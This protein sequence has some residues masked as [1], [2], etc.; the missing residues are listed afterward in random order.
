MYAAIFLI[1]NRFEKSLRNAELPFT[2][3]TA[4]AKKQP[5]N[6]SSKKQ[7]YKIIVT[8]NIFQTV[9]DAK[10]STILKKAEP[11]SPTSLNLSLVGTIVGE[12][13]DSRAIILNPVTKKQELFM[14][15]DQIQGALIKKIE[16]G[17]VVLQVNRQE[18]TLLLEERKSDNR[19]INEPGTVVNSISSNMPQL[20][21]SQD[22]SLRKKPILPHRRTRIDSDA[23]ENQI[24]SENNLNEEDDRQETDLTEI[25]EEQVEKPDE[26]IQQEE[27][28]MDTQQIDND[29]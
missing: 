14:E 9:P 17:N 11:P 28:D 20:T 21:R 13:K 12:K 16:R 23:T 18:E 7:D 3:F 5:D 26:Q 19:A 25:D 22:N 27:I 6:I 8:R 29:Q 15:G 24:E 2:V 4:K 1:Y 10:D